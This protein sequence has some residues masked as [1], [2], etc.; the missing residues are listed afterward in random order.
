MTHI[1][2]LLFIFLLNRLSSYKALI[3]LFPQLNQLKIFGSTVYIFIY[4]EKI[5]AKLVE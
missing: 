4:K 5:K 3:G 1:F 2:K